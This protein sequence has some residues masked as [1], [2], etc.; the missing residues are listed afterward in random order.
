MSRCPDDT[1]NLQIAGW[2]IV[3]NIQRQHTILV[4]TL[5]M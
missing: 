3:D 2:K 5:F 1:N 4:D